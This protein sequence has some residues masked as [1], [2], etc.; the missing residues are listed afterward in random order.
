MT[1]GISP[2]L[3]HDTILGVAYPACAFITVDGHTFEASEPD[4]WRQALAI[5]AV[6]AGT[7]SI[8]AGNAPGLAWSA[9]ARRLAFMVRC[10]C[11]KHNLDVD[12]PDA[13]G[14]HL[15]PDC[16]HLAGWENAHSDYDHDSYPDPDCPLCRPAADGGEG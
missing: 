3:V 16:Y 12:Q 9:A 6:T 15:C 4:D 8:P 13:F 2:I 7:I 11:G 1:E 10:S 5:A 14:L